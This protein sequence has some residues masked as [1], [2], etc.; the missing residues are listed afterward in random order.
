MVKRRISVFIGVGVGLAVGV[1]ST[2]LC[3]GVT[4]FVLVYVWPLT[5][6]PGCPD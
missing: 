2:I 5:V 4:Y 3:Y 1:L 6:L